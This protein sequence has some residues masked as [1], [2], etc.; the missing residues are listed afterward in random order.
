MKNRSIPNSK[1]DVYQIITDR[2][3]AELEKGVAVWRK[4]WRMNANLVSGLEYRGVNQLILMTSEYDS[5]LWLTFKQTKQRGGHVKKGAQGWPVVFWKIYPVE[6]KDGEK[7]DDVR[8]IARYYTVFN[9]SQTEGVKAP[10]RK[11]QFETHAGAEEIVRNYLEAAKLERRDGGTRAY[12]SLKH[13]RVQMP[14][15]TSFTGDEAGYYNTVFHE[16]VH[17]TGIK[18]R[19]DRGIEKNGGSLFAST[20]YSKEEL[21]AEL[22][23]AMLCGIAGVKPE[24]NQNAAYIAGWL[25]PLRDDRAI[26]VYAAQQAQK[27]VDLILGREADCDG[28]QDNTAGGSDDQQE[29]C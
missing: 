2:V 6:D 22:G 1:K 17:S 27:A 16:L 11:P 19:L 29:V 13:D 18:G 15:L 5:E 21:V 28:E 9:L 8:I 23:A 20:S 7:Q 3:I 10:E 26:L 24:Y 25:K 4:P 14:P 12:Y